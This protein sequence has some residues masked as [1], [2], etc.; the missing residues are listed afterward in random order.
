MIFSLAKNTA[1]NILHRILFRFKNL[2][3]LKSYLQHEWLQIL[4]GNVNIQDFIIAKEVR[5]GNYSGPVPP[6]G[7]FL[8][9]K[10]MQKDHRLE[11]QYGERVP[12]IIVHSGPA[13]RLVDAAVSPEDFLNNG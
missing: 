4:N 10:K 7:A 1:A 6:P 8:S 11:P 5:L 3:E 2:S 9:I 13:A 12:Y